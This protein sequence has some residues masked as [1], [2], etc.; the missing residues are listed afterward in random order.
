M[1]DATLRQ[2]VADAKQEMFNL[3]FQM[4]TGKAVNTARIRKLRKDIARIQT[5]LHERREG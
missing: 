5:V 1:D 4:A 2:Q 3:R